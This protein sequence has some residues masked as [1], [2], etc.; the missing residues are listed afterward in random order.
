MKSMIFHCTVFWRSFAVEGDGRSSTSS[1]RPTSGS[2][3]LATMGETTMSD[4]ENIDQDK[5]WGAA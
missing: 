3:E 1:T 2:A 5:V 4:V